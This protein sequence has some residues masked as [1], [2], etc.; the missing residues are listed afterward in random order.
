MAQTLVLE[1]P[2]NVYR[3]LRRRAEKTGKTPEK[4]AE[5][6]IVRAA[7]RADDDPVLKCIGAFSSGDPHWADEHD[8]YFAGAVVGEEE[9]E[10]GDEEK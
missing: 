1:L 2:E 9:G 6:L 5:D 7:E 3:S 4:I 10:Y 8:K